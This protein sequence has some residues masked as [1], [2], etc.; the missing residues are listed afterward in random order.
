MFFTF[1]CWLGPE[2]IPAA[3]QTCRPQL[4]IG[5]I[6]S[7]YAIICTIHFPHSLTLTKV[8][9]CIHDAAEFHSDFLAEQLYKCVGSVR[10]SNYIFR[11]VESRLCGWPKVFSRTRPWISDAV[12]KPASTG[13]AF[14][15][16][17]V[18]KAS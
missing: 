3:I 2:L 1:S 14:P 15:L 11:L 5:L 4:I 16:H 17:Y 13:L 10:Y 8:S 9:A 18:T 6:Y 7:Y 12:F